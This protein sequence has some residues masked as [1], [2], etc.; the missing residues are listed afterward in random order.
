MGREVW[1]QPVPRGDAE[2][3]QHCW[4]EDPGCGDQVW[5]P[6]MRCMV[7]FGRTDVPPWRVVGDAAPFPGFLQ[8]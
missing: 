7:S 8:S 6:L 1:E 3:T 5:Q 4:K 2:N